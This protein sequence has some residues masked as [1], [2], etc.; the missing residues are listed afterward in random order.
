MR[1]GFSCLAAVDGK[2]SDIG[3][4]ALVQ[5][6]G[7]REGAERSGTVRVLRG[8]LNR[9]GPPYREMVKVSQEVALLIS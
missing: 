8:Y 9:G 5:L 1:F 2:P 3:G 7:Y 4:G 6:L